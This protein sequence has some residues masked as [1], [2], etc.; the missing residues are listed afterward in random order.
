MNKIKVF[1]LAIASLSAAFGQVST[2]LSNAITAKQQT[3][4]LASITNVAAPTNPVA[5]SVIGAPTN[6]GYTILVVDAEQMAVFSV[7]STAAGQVRVSRGYG[8]TKMAAH[9]VGAKVWVGLQSLFANLRPSLTTGRFRYSTVAIGSV[10]YTSVGTAVSSVAGTLYCADVL[11]TRDMVAT[12]IGV[13]NAGTVAT[14]LGI[15]ALYDSSG[16][17]IAN[18]AVAGA[19]TVGANVFQDRA[20]TAVTVIQGPAQYYAC[21][22]ANNNTDNF[23]TVAASTMIDVLTRSATGTFGTVPLTITLPTTFTADVGPVAYIY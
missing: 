3:V 12:G 10:A 14:S 6:G 2:T 23:R 1:A 17:L 8:G 11:V 7:P 13:L 4:V 20:F 22:Q 18:S 21:Y 9:A 16:T 5:S 15:V 19:V